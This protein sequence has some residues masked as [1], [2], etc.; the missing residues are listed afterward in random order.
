MKSGKASA[1][2]VA[3]GGAALVWSTATAGIASAQNLEPIINTN[4]SY[5][6]AVA[7]LDANDPAAAAQFH[8]SPPAQ[9]FMQQ[10]LA[11]PRDQ[12]IQMAAQMQ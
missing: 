5:S 2:V 9:A 1:W 11:A 7:A 8:G 6:Q 4:C 3:L 12:R 10:Y